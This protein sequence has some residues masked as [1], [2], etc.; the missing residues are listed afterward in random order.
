MGFVLYN[1]P[2][3]S[4]ALIQFNISSCVCNLNKA[5]LSY[6]EDSKLTDLHN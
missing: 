4:N 3:C 2:D 1:A 6:T 5:L